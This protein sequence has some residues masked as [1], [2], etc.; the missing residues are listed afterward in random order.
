MSLDISMDSSA[1]T[2]R[3]CS[4]SPSAPADII[5]TRSR[6]IASAPALHLRHGA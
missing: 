5:P 2:S 4:R 3:R 1:P 6:T